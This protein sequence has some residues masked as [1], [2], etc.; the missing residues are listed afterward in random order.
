V[1]HQALSNVARGKDPYLREGDA[2]NAEEMEDVMIH[3]SDLVL[4]AAVS[5]D[6]ELSHLDVYV[7]DRDKDNLYV[8]HDYML[9][10]FPLALAWLDFPVGAERADEARRENLVAVATFE[11][12]IEIWDLDTFDQPAPLALLGG[13]EDPADLGRKLKAKQLTAESHRDAVL[14]L[15]W[16][17]QQRNLLA[18][19]SADGTVK[20]W[21]LC[22]GK[23]LRTLRHHGGAKV[24]CLA[25]NPSEAPLL[26]SGAY[27][28]RVAV[29]DVRAPE[30]AVALARLD[31]DVEALLWLPAPRHSHL[32]VATESGSLYCFDVAQGLERPLWRLQAHA[33]KPL[34]AL[35]LSRAWDGAL[36]ATG[37]TDRHAP[38]K[39]WQLAADNAQPPLCL[40]E[41]AQEL[42]PLFS[43]SFSRDEPL[44][45]V[46]GVQGDRP[47]IVDVTHFD[48]IKAK[49]AQWT[50]A[51]PDQPLGAP[52]LSAAA[53]VSGLA[54]GTLSAA[55][56][57]LPPQSP[58]TA[59]SS[60]SSSSSSIKTKKVK[61]KGK[62]G[63][64]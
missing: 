12:Y 50:A 15:A 61:G 18:S 27:D 26:A 33:G 36:L 19:A 55:L 42:G 17:A 35:A 64:R 2:V 25:W 11:P 16:N 62:A 30:S 59:T 20:L 6:E 1:L 44:L 52:A 40:Y 32:L 3:T 53:T 58:A 60:S 47:A 37:T 39:L 48:A 49:H 10:A 31:A 51:H 34:Q 8:H 57:A 21:D 45:L 54:P 9:P 46:A 5:E 13:P 7:Y 4:L 24:Q 56:A 41:G 63:R 43:L 23:C 29:V 22:T 14:S 28:Q 38:L